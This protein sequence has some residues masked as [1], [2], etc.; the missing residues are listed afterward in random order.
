MQRL[1]VTAFTGLCVLAV[2]AWPIR[3]S[4]QTAQA[5]AGDYVDYLISQ[6]RFAHHDDDRK[7]AAKTLGKIGD[8]RAMPAL[9]DA[10]IYDDEDDVR[11]E[12]RKAIK[13]IGSVRPVVVAPAPASV[14]TPTTAPMAVPAPAPVTVY[15]ERIVEVAPPPPPPPVVYRTYTVYRTY[16]YPVYVAPPPAVIV[17]GYP[18]CW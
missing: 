4:A 7:D 16:H 17:R 13:R 6:L 18:Y 12:A 5:P 11:H 2:L 3:L 10:A 15:R 1:G 8:P 14:P 9:Q